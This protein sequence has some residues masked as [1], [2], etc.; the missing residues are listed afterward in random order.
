[1]IASSIIMSRALAPI[2]V[3]IAHWRGFIAAR[4]GLKRLGAALEASTP[5]N[6]M[7]LP[8][9]EGHVRVETVFAGPIGVKDPV[10]KGL[11]F[12]LAPGDALGV[13]GPSGSD[14]STL[15]RVLVGVWPA[16]RGRVCLDGAPLEHWPLGQVGEHIGYLPQEAA[17]FEGTVADNIARFDTKAGPQAIIAAARSANVHEMILGLS[18][19]YN[20]RVGEGGAVLSGGQRQRIAL[21]RTLYG[22]LALIVLDEP[23]SNLDQAGEE[24]LAEA[25]ATMRRAG[26]TVVVMAHRRKA[27]EHV[28][29]ILV[30]KDGRQAAFGD[31]ATI[32]GAAQKS[33]EQKWRQMHATS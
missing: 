15:A 8:Q 9:P 29:H 26:R 25:I 24:A 28:S 27:L 10:L 33:A 22:G 30:L 1:M 16:L 19:G 2:E 4:Q 6:R 23:N 20:T 17:L 18:D 11:D 21:A 31:K 32:L 12:E 7:S 3:G 13:L 14:K 5:Q